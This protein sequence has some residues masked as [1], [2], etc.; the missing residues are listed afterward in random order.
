[1][2][3]LVLA[4]AS[5]ASLASAD[6]CFDGLETAAAEEEGKDEDWHQVLDRRGLNRQDNCHPLEEIEQDF[7]TFASYGICLWEQVGWYEPSNTGW[8]NIA[9]YK[10]DV[11]SLVP[12]LSASL[13]FDGE[14]GLCWNN[15][16]SDIYDYF[17]DC[18]Y[19]SDEWE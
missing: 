14:M 9:Q 2:I 13:Q 1:M 4:L 16:T 6:L 10:A 18:D 11:E 19:S 17:Q 8:I 7:Y 3:R 15:M 5:L 12:D